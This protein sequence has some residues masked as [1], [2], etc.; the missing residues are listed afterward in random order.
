MMGNLV[1]Q[2]Y[3]QSQHA[4]I[5]FRS[6]S[7]FSLQQHIILVRMGCFYAKMHAYIWAPF[8]AVRSNSGP[9]HHPLHT[10]ATRLFGLH[11]FDRKPTHTGVSS[12]IR[13]AAALS[14]PWQLQPSNLTSP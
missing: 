4:H 13:G 12:A 5:A 10:L 14:K 6:S 2:F 1:D 7:N 8:P 3:S 11:T 9:S